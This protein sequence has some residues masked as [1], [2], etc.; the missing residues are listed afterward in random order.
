MTSHLYVACSKIFYAGQVHN[1]SSY[2]HLYPPTYT[3]KNNFLKFTADMTWL[4][5]FDLHHDFY[6]L[7]G[8][9]FESCEKFAFHHTYFKKK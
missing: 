7:L 9:A 6:C 5:E 1:T 4:T 2:S 3:N 8:P